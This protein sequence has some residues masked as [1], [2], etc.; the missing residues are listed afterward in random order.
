MI[1]K[2]T[3]LEKKE[4]NKQKSTKPL[5]EDA[6]YVENNDSKNILSQ[7]CFELLYF[8]INYI[9][10]CFLRVAKWCKIGLSY[11]FSENAVLP[12]CIFQYNC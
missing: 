1:I 9:L 10:N 7:C 5:L 12:I 3:Q 4:K 11:L 2:I 8:S 6:N